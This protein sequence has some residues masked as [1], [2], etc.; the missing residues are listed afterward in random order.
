MGGEAARFMLDIKVNEM[1]SLKKK[2]YVR[3][4]AGK[5]EQ[6]KEVLQLF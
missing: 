1:H 5:W 6:I 2:G 3:R 4:K